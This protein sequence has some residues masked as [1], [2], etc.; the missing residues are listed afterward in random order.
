MPPV[1]A[2]RERVAALRADGRR[3]IGMGQAV[4]WTGPPREALSELAGM[5]QHPEMHRYSP[6]QGLPG[7]LR[8]LAGDLRERRGIETDPDGELHLTC[9][10]SQAFLG[11]LLAAVPHGGSVTVI[12]PYYFDHVFAIRFCGIGM[13]S[14]RME[15]G[16]RWELP[17]EELESAVASTDALVLVDP[18]NPTGSVLDDDGM[19][20][21]VGMTRELG[22]FLI[23]DETYERFRFDRRSAHPWVARREPH[24]LTI[25]SFSKSLGMAGWRL[26][27]L[28]GDAG[29]LE[30]ALKV[31]DSVVI[32]PPVASQVLLELS[33]RHPAWAEELSKGV[34]MRRDLCREALRGCEGLEWRGAEGAFFTLARSRTGMT[35]LDAAMH[36]IEAHGLA[37]IPGSAFGEAGS[38]H[39]RLSFGCLPE[40]ELEP[41][42]R[43]LAGVSFPS[44]P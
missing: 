33:L 5:L 16:P 34:E 7:P 27:Y 31:Q 40:E 23:L 19:R 12:E 43:A 4:P 20:R 44:R 35:D 9:G 11:A 21:V 8:A 6:D 32:C 24:V 30:Q 28:F 26:G 3:V 14:V 39:L 36:L 41:A 2:V 37:A 13:R 1:A 42:M 22:S 29:M 15:E 18:G 17:W 38:G 10:A 25:G